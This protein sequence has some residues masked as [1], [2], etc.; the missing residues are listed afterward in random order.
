[1][2][3]NVDG[4]RPTWQTG[5]HMSVK[6]YRIRT[7]HPSQFINITTDVE[8][9]V[10]ESGITDGVAIVYVPHTTAGV[11]I[12]ENADPSVP[13][14]IQ[15][16]LDQLVPKSSAFT[17][18]EGNSDSHIKATIVGSSQTVIINDGHLL[19]GTWQGV[20]FCEFDG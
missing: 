18:S 7:A 19:L 6:E 17:H 5:I 8:E 1:M 2:T 15:H 16:H 4:A 10:S 9:A 14:D 13:R 20:F 11:T 12:N 3:H